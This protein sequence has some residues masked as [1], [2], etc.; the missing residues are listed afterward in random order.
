MKQS[1]RGLAEVKDVFGK[2]EKV[3]KSMLLEKDFEDSVD[4]GFVLY[5][6]FYKNV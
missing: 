2:D 6:F 5:F 1:T 4:A 3:E